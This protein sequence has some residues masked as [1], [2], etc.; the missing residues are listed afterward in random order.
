MVSKW[1]KNVEIKRYQ[2]SLKVTDAGALIDYMFS[3]PGNIK[4]TMTVDKLKAMVK[5]LNDIIKSEGAIR[6]GKDTG[7]FHGIKF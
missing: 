3:M 6:I 7:F 1:F 4:E 5:Y 2:D